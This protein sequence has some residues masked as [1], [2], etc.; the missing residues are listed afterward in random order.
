M[1][2]CYVQ[3]DGGITKTILVKGEGWESPEQGDEVEGRRAL[4]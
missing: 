4:S 1:S 2:E 3:E